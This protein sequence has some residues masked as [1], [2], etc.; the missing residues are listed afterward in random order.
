MA[1]VDYFCNWD[2]VNFSVRHKEML[3]AKDEALANSLDSTF[4]LKILYCVRN[5]VSRLM[6]LTKAETAAFCVL[7]DSIYR[8]YEDVLQVVFR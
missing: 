4:P 5:K 3:K 6:P 2:G 7:F 1:I 8:E